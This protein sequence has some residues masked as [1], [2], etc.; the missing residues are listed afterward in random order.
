MAREL[1]RQA[2]CPSEQPETLPAELAFICWKLSL[3]NS[4]LRVWKL[5]GIGVSRRALC[6]CTAG[7]PARHVLCPR[8]WKKVDV[9]S[10]ASLECQTSVTWQGTRC[11]FN[12]SMT[13]LINLSIGIFWKL[14][15]NMTRGAVQ[16]PRLTQLLSLRLA[17]R[18]KMCNK[19]L[20]WSGSER[21]GF[22]EWCTSVV[23][24]VG[25]RDTVLHSRSWA[26]RG[27]VGKI[28]S[29]KVNK[30]C[31]LPTFKIQLSIFCYIKVSASYPSH[32]LYIW[33]WA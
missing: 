17:G 27:H 29:Q 21:W 33:L 22:Q 9:S 32:I 6:T 31:I 28:L 25:S 1:H 19:C 16:S 15:R 2:E 13:S 18:R 3:W 26:V 8:P 30:N 10:T 4:Q 11:F 20:L 5:V 7:L 24:A 14:P 12:R 23:P